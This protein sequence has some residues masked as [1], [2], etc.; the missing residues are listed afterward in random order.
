MGIKLSFT[1]MNAQM[2]LLPHTARRKPMQKILCK[3]AKILL[4]FMVITHYG[5]TLTTVSAQAIRG[6]P[7][8]P[9]TIV[10]YVDFQCP[11]CAQ[12]K[13]LVDQVLT[14]YDGKVQLNLKHYPHATHPFAMSAAQVFEVLERQDEEKAWAF[15]DL[16]MAEQSVLKNSNNGLQYLVDKLD[17]SQPEKDQLNRDLAD[18]TIEQA[19]KND[20][21]EEDNLGFHSTPAFFINGIHLANERSL[22]DFSQLIDSLL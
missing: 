12:A 5:T 3:I 2:L 8:A 21:A 20:I 19:I 18:P 22:D 17:L 4:F 13:K 9:I 14:K 1:F 7:L 10:E 16:A 11:A 15:Y 6:N